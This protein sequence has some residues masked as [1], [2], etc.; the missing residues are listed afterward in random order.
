MTT[1]CS[2]NH[3][4]SLLILLPLWPFRSRRTH[5]SSSAALPPHKVLFAHSPHAQL[6]LALWYHHPHPHP[7]LLLCFTDSR[8]PWAWALFLPCSIAVCSRSGGALLTLH[9]HLSR[10][11]LP[12]ERIPPLHS[13][14][15]VLSYPLAIRT[16]FC[17]FV[18]MFVPS[19]PRCNRS[20]STSPGPVTS[21]LAGNLMKM[22]VLRPSPWPSRG[23]DWCMRKSE[24]HPVRG[25]CGKPGPMRPPGCCALW[26]PCLLGPAL[27]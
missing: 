9:S 2:L 16:K 21:A 3:S 14:S 5:D 25:R 19:L 23:S 12:L 27:D 4:A 20:S 7:T 24:D 15:Q 10:N 8:G 18:L 6:T 13:L 17:V 22:Q 26:I 11:R 1:A